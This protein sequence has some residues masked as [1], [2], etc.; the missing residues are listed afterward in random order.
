MISDQAGHT[1]NATALGCSRLC[2]MSFHEIDYLVCASFSVVRIPTVT[3]SGR[4]WDVKRTKFISLL[5]QLD[6][7]SFFYGKFI[8]CLYMFRAPCS[9]NQEVK[10]VLYI[11]WYHHT[12]RWPSGAQFERGFSQ[13]VHGMATYRCDDTRCCMLQF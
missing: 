2:L 12:Y 3:S 5:N 8:S 11:I 13:P 1:C 10:I 4:G 6:A 9:H 7:Q